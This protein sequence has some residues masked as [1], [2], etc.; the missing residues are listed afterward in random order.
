MVMEKN[1]C[2][3][4]DLL[5]CQKKLVI[6]ELCQAYVDMRTCTQTHVC[7]YICDVA[8]VTAVAHMLWGWGAQWHSRKYNSP[9]WQQCFAEG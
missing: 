2:Y 1:K 6:L 4:D 9:G 7:R 5:A 3:N 8:S